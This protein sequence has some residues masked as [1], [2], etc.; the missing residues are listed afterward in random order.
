MLDQE[1]HPF[2]LP[3]LIVFCMMNINGHLSRHSL[4]RAGKRKGF[5]K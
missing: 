5:S 2:I 4:S 3:V 1:Q